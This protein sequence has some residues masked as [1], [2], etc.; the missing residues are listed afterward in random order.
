MR[1]FINKFST[2]IVQFLCCAPTVHCRICAC[3]YVAA[4]SSHNLDGGKLKVCKAATCNITGIRHTHA[5]NLHV[6]LRI[7]CCCNTTI[8]LVV[9]V[10]V[11]EAFF[12]CLL[13]C[14]SHICLHNML[15]DMWHWNLKWQAS[16]PQRVCGIMCSAVLYR[17]QYQQ[18][19]Q[20]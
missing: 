18:Q 3:L 6:V 1:W 2:D 4:T 5:H 11:F 9:F 15:A 19:Q 12:F 10:V 7:C 13:A 16:V 17:Q 14:C 20:Q 8:Q